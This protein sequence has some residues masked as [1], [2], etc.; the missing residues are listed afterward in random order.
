MA[1][2][3]FN[4]P[5]TDLDGEKV[6]KVNAQGEETGETLMLGQLLGNVLAADNK[7]KDPVKF[8]DW[9]LTIGKRNP[10]P[11]ILDRSD[12]KTLREF[13]KSHDVFSNLQKSQLIDILD[14]PEST[15]ENLE[16]QIQ[17]H[18]KEA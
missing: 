17:K 10:E 11:L 9:A 6:S 8:A 2:F 5:M 16:Q 3:N 1:K 15:T 4:H 13:I 12:Q 7:T 14:N 18:L